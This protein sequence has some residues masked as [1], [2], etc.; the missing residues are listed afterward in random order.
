MVKQVK[1][2]GEWYEVRGRGLEDGQAEREREMW[3]G[4]SGRSVQINS[5]Q[6]ERK[7][8]LE[9]DWAVKRQE[10]GVVRKGGGDIIVDQEV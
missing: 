2:S 3:E 7:V 8:R 5:R 1:E 9:G 4:G 6:A 10:Y